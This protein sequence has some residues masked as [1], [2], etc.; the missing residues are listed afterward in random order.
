LAQYAFW[1][2][3]V[4]AL[5]YLSYLFAISMAVRNDAEK[6]FTDW[7]KDLG[8]LD[9]NNP[10]DPGLYR[11]FHKTIQPGLRSGVSP[12]SVAAMD[13]RFGTPL[14]GFR[15]SDLVGICLRNHG[16]L[17]FTPQG[18]VDWKMTPK[19]VQ[20]PA[21]L[22]A[23]L[24]ATVECPEGVYGLNVAMRATTNEAGQRDWQLIPAATGL[25]KTAR[26]TDFGR[27]VYELKESGRQAG[28]RFLYFVQNPPFHEWAYLLFVR[29]AYSPT[30]EENYLKSRP[31]LGGMAVAG[32]TYWID[33]SAAGYEN[34][35]VNR[36]F[37]PQL[38]PDASKD[39]DNQ[40]KKKAEMRKQF[41]YIWNSGRLRIAGTMVKDNPDKDPVLVIEEERITMRYPIELGLPGG[42]SAAN[43]ARGRIVFECRDPAVIAEVRKERAAADPATATDAYPKP[44][45]Q[46]LH[47]TWKV[48]RIESDLVPLPYTPPRA[49]G[50]MMP[51][52]G[53]PG[54]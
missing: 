49:E 11:A 28:E 4:G 53:G 10:S 31:L 16:Q 18:L 40:A 44:D 37:E 35:L 21:I 23:T 45:W 51:G 43:T 6:Q 42:D 26:L 7:V 14:A 17:H 9:P 20:S 46:P 32:S 22:D 34:Y 13:R 50:G 48:V 24:A 29:A 39:P 19:T 2:G 1:I 47:P 25:V 15:Q 36:V 52:M 5:G 27:R 54:G 38:G 8:D 12:E 41:A 30:A 33:G 3:L